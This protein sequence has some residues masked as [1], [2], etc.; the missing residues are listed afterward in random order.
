MSTI[1]A[2]GWG[3]VPDWIGGI[4]TAAVTILLAIGWWR[5]SRHRRHDQERQSAVAIRQ[6]LLDIEDL[7]AAMSPN[8]VV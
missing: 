3:S 2:T 1:A 5:K 4:E 8:P 6:L 7:Y